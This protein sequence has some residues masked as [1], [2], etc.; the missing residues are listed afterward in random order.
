MTSRC[1]LL[2]IFVLAGCQS[3]ERGQGS[4][5]G[6]SKSTSTAV[7][8]E[9]PLPAPAPAPSGPLPGKR[10]E[11]S[12]GKP[13]R[14]AIGDFDGDHTNEIAVADAERLRV[15]TAAGKE[16]ASVPAP[17]GLHVLVATDVDGDGRAEIVA[18]WGMSRDHK[19]APARI[20]MYR[21]E[22]DHL[23]EEEILAP[24][25]SRA[26]VVAVVPW[27]ANQLLLAYYSSKY[28][29]KSV[30]ATRSPG[31]WAIAPLA[32]IR[33]ATSYA[34][35]DVDGDGKP[36]LVVGRVYGDAQGVD[37]DAFV[38]APAGT[39]TPIPTTRG[40]RS[41]VIA[42]GEVFLADGWHQNYAQSA[43]ALLT[44]SRFAQGA[45]HSELVEDM[46]GQ[47]MNERIV[48]AT[49][50]GRTALVTLGN[51]AVRVYT[52]TDGK[53]HG[54]TIAGPSRDIAVGDLDGRPGDEI[55]VVGD[56]TEIVDLT[57]T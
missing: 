50:H 6:S 47:F 35:G 5:T 8:K 1:T 16:L 14:A 53:W 39:R 43:H 28:M 22:H 57:G 32:E 33:M 26:E 37:G 15:V 42:D 52:K 49:I 12:L 40:V 3:G 10:T 56:H 45:F 51:Q 34:R 7:R 38:L 44:V 36:D 11:L 23:V 21:L 30:I 9:M 20:V 4:S 29:V 55:L 2:A 48:R 19:T 46:A 24:E 25:T 13:L 27:E 31:G 17:S 41:M 18:G 54:V